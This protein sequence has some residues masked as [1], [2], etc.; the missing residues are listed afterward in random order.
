MNKTIEQLL[1]EIKVIDWQMLIHM[2]MGKLHRS[3]HSGVFDCEGNPLHGKKFIQESDTEMN[4]YAKCGR[5][6][7]AYYLDEPNSKMFKT[8]KA[9][10]KYYNKI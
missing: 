1:Q 4:G 6:T 2:N 3:K 9:M 8:L 5:T 10:V 7:Y